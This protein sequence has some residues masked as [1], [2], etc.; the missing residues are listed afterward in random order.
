MPQ[1]K[2]S[3]EFVDRYGFGPSY[4]QLAYPNKWMRQVYEHRGLTVYIDRQRRPDNRFEVFVVYPL[5]G[6]C[7][8]E[9]YA[10]RQFRTWKSAE[11][12]AEQMVDK[13]IERKDRWQT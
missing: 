9:F 8:D 6:W 7:V 13:H 1:L 12:R 10:N 4:G 3:M 11:A 2:K 5:G